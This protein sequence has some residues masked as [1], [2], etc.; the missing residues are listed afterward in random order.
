M[1]E[2]LDRSDAGIARRAGGRL[3]RFNEAGVLDAADVHVAQRLGALCGCRDDAALLGA[4]LAV[5]GA[6]LGHV[7]IDLAAAPR[8]VG[9]EREEGADLGALDWP[10]EWPSV[11]GRSGLVGAALPLRLEGERLY[12]ARYFGAECQ[13]AE[14]L[15]A[16]AAEPAPG[17][18]PGVLATGLER[19]FAGGE[20]PDLQ[21]LAAATAVLR[22]LSVIGGGPGTGKTT[23][24]ARV[25]ALLEEQAVA[26]GARP[27]L[28]ALAAPTGKA[29]ARLDEA[30]KE[31][32]GRLA[33]AEDLRARL[34]APQGQTLHRLL[35]WS[36]N[37]T[38]FAHHRH[39]RLAHDV[40][41][42]DET[43]MVSL[44]LMARLVEAVRPDARLVLLGDPEQLA[45][46]EAGAVLGDLVGPAAGGLRMRARAREALRG[47]SGQE[48]P[49][50]EPE[51]DTPI[52][53]GIV[54]LRKVH[55]YGGAILELTEAVR[56]GRVDETLAILDAG[57]PEVTWLDAG[58]GP[59]ALSEVRAAA[60]AAGAAVWEAAGRGDARAA[61]AA[62][63]A[64]RLLCAHRHGPEGAATWNR[65][66]E[67]WLGAALDGFGAG[68]PFYAGRPL[69][70]TENDYS[71]RLFNGDT[72][73]VTAGRDGR[74]AAAFERGRDVVEVSPARL[75]AVDTVYAM[76]V[77]KAQGSQ[78][79]TVAVV[80]PGPESPILT[81][82]LLY[83]ALSR[84][85]DRVLVA[86]STEAVATAVARPI[87][88]A[89]GLRQRLWGR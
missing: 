26:A 16:L 10:E 52:G 53:D 3:A 4:A 25:L 44:T 74:P 7:C 48:V 6:R 55:R 79:S 77:H 5:R 40:V 2:G 21:R 70:V 33:V 81:R 49:A 63:G 32:A 36:P 72:G 86:G 23:T 41:V 29:A 68:G 50:D 57:R 76:T 19:L 22:R 35:G 84:G 87:A 12:L 58:T 64:F 14:D 46:V 66:I 27:P 82:E 18:D 65:T 78:F 42:V 30:V 1:T 60:V 62:L 15:L 85:R 20:D 71:L 69:L 11:M 8:T 37:R 24:V 83:T 28:V 88:R 89:T 38:R 80:L 45:S 75:A 51:G 39:N 56:R 34:L 43:S 13:V 47:V 67:H 54:V 59:E 31:E 61:I 73:V 17:V 9:S